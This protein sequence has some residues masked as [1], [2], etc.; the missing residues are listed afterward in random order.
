MRYAVREAYVLAL[1]AVR[2]VV[3]VH[4]GALRGHLA[5]GGVLVTGPG[6]SWV[7]ASGVVAA[8]P[9]CRTDRVPAGSRPAPG[10]E[11]VSRRSLRGW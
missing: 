3:V 5:G 1:G 9:R 4:F 2:Q 7:V 10:A 6:G 11:R 8:R